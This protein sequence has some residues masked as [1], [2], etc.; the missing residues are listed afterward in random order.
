MHGVP[1]SLPRREMTIDEWARLPEDE[2]GELVDG[3]LANEELPDLIHETVVSWLIHVLRS[4]VIARGG[5]VFGSEARFVVAE[6]SGRKPDVT[7]Y[8]PGGRP[9]PRRG[10]VRIPPDVAVEVVSPT[11]R[12]GR[13]DRVE[14]PDEYA[15]FGVRFYWIID[16][17][18]RTLE[19]FELGTDGR[20]VRALA[21]AD[22]KV[23]GVPGCGELVLDLDALWAEVERLAAYNH[24]PMSAG[25]PP[26]L[27]GTYAIASDT[28][29]L[30]LKSNSTVQLTKE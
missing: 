19:M 20:Y 9:L 2:A 30:A 15:R 23:Q 1:I 17:E 24:G 16:P 4:W 18:E 10:A 12:D 13:R 11:P 29:T 6:R 25:E 8:L 26:P 3:W 7:M 5:F 27:E 22:G 21:A 28:L 14:K